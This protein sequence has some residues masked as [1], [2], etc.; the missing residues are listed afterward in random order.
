MVPLAI[1]EKLGKAQN[2]ERRDTAGPGERIET[3]HYPGLT[4]VYDRLEN[5]NLAM[6]E[7]I[8]FKPPVVDGAPTASAAPPAPSAARPAPS[9]K[10][11]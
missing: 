7:I 10:K 4:V 1:E 11:P 6:A 8:V 5:G 3:H 9:A 2:V